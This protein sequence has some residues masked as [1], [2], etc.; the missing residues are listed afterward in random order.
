[1]G[2]YKISVVTPFHNVET[3]FFANTVDAMKKQTIGFENIEW[4]IVFHNCEKRYIDGA[5]A[6]LHG[7]GNVRTEIIYNEIRTPSSPRNHGLSMVTSKA[8]GFLDADDSYTPICLEEALGHMESSGAEIVWFRREYERENSNTIPITEVVLWNQ[9]YSEIIIDRNRNWD[10]EKL[11]SGLFGLVTS[12]I[13]NVDFLR[14]HNITFDESVRF[15]EDYLFNFEA[16]GRVHRLCYLPQ[17]IGYHYFINSGS[18]VQSSN[19]KPEDI[20]EIARGITRVFDTGLKYGFYMDAVMGGLIFSVMRFMLG[21]PSVTLEDRFT[22]KEILAPY[23]EILKPIRVSKLYPE[24]AVHE[25]YHTVMDYILHPEKWAHGED[26][27]HMLADGDM[28]AMNAGEMNLLR[29]ILEKNSATDMGRRYNFNDI[30]TI[31]GFRAMVPVS[32]YETY[33]PLMALTSRIGESAV[34]SAEPVKYYIRFLD[35]GYEQRMLPVTESHIATY[36]EALDGVCR[37]HTTLPLFDRLFKKTNFNDNTTAESVYAAV[38]QSYIE[39]R[40]DAWDTGT[41]LVTPAPSLNDPGADE[42]YSRVLYALADETLTQIF[43]PN[44]YSVL[45]LVDFIAKNREQLCRDIELGQNSGS[46]ESAKAG[47]IYTIK[48]NPERARVVRAALSASSVF[49]LRSLW[50]QFSAITAVKSGEFRYYTDLLSIMIGD[51]TIRSIDMIPEAMLGYPGK[52]DSFILNT[53]GGFYELAEVSEGKVCAEPILPK[54]VQAGKSYLL[55]VTNLAGLYRYNT[56]RYIH[57][58]K[59]DENGE[60]CYTSDDALVSAISVDGIRFDSETLLRAAE[61]LRRDGGARA[62]DYCCSGDESEGLVVYLQPVVSGGIRHEDVPKYEKMLDEFFSKE[63]PGYAEA[64]SAGSV[65]Q[66]S[67]RILAE[68]TTHLYAEL[69][70]GKYD[71]APDT[72]TPPHIV[73]QPESLRFLR[74]TS[75]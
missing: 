65:R 4:I 58:E 12:R 64:R 36:F 41:R 8:V 74:L 69:T 22:I 40:R 66:P 61:H 21:C 49:N 75:L 46:G 6:L 23:L 14:K 31:R 44:T 57:I 67:V 33:R 72:V 50:P 37:G 11:F 18:I 34:F 59:I 56:E 3:S 47:D 51:V 27:D 62:F 7:C 43:A 38:L 24:K 39:H 13:Y 20:I 68:E 32:G 10:N 54:D 48:A 2:N 60:I 15:A 5:M 19:K 35:R 63:L 71:V 42:Y 25:R 29:E 16:Y 30:I 1:M 53:K 9:T 55:Y 52:G 26:A 70:A 45:R 17:M 73:L 28:K